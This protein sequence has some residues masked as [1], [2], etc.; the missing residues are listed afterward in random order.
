[1]KR[2]CAAL[3]AGSLFFASGNLW[4]DIL[5]IRGRGYVNGRVLSDDGKKITFK[6]NNG[7]VEVLPKSEVTY[8][9]KETSRKTFAGPRPTEK[10]SIVDRVRWIV[11]K[12]IDDLT[13]KCS[14]W[15]QK[16]KDFSKPVKRSQSPA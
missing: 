4:A 15:S 12:W 9:E 11:Q 3:A 5:E 1:M 7:R 8:F 13:G 16:L 10:S 2:F 6:N 14:E